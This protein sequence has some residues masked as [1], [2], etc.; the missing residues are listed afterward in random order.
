MPNHT[1]TQVQ[2][3]GPTTTLLPFEQHLK[4]QEQDP[5]YPVGFLQKF[6][7]YDKNLFSG[8]TEAWG[9]KWDVYELGNIEF[10]ETPNYHGFPT[11]AIL[12]CTW[13]TAWSPCIE[14]M[15]TLSQ[16]YDVTVKL[17]YI[18][19]G[20]F[21]VGTTTIIGG[22]KNYEDS[23]SGDDVPEGMYKLFGADAWLNEFELCL[24]DMD[25]PEQ[26]LKD[27]TYVD[28][29]ARRRAKRRIKKHLAQIEPA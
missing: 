28:Q 27:M 15:L 17:T 23:Y 8:N 6:V 5:H 18:D 3:H 22:E 16:L 19:E 4:L 7:P 25:D 2:I 20:G 14:A 26:V 21:Y 1:A 10:E 24:P 11:T 9:T 29:N 12:K 13:H